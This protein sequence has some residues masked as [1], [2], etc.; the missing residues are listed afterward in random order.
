MV[1]SH[2]SFSFAPLIMSGP[3]I[4]HGTEV[5]SQAY[6]K[7]CV[8]FV[9]CLLKLFNRKQIILFDTIKFCQCRLFTV[10]SLFLIIALY[11]KAGLDTAKSS[12][13]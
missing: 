3:R 11:S 10:A 12:G 1:G 2:A 8:I 4:L 6:I 9:E 5:S 13:F 7:I